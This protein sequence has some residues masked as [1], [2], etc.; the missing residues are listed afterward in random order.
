MTM[1]SQSLEEIRVYVGTY[2]SGGSEGI[3]LYRMD[4]STGALERGRTVARDIANP[5]FVALDPQGRTLYSVEEMGYSDGE[6]SGAVSA[7]SIDPE[8]GDLTY[9]NRQ[10]SGGDGPCHLSVDGTGRYVL[11]AN[12][13][14]GNASML[15]VLEGGGLG[16][17]TGFVQHEGGSVLERQAGP[18]A[19][20]INLDPGNRYAFVADLGLD[21]VMIYRLDLDRGKLI[22]GD[23]PWAEVQAGAGPRHFDFHPNGRY[24]YL[25]NEIGN[26]MT[27]FAYD[28]ARGA[29][30]EVQTASTLPEAFSGTSYTADVH[31]APSGKFVYGSNRGHDS[32][33][34][35]GI[36]EGTGRMTPLG[37]EP[38]QG[39]SPRNF[40]IDPT[41]TFLLAANQETGNVVTFRMDQG[42]GALVPTGHVTEIPAPVCLEMIAIAS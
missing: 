21:K 5:S 3:Y 2:T 40:G 4:P 22:P 9:L 8:T 34:I 12:Y 29:L 7:F 33:A 30:R 16:E 11:V 23:E 31:V 6:P 38:T 41:G 1:T 32:I 24:A 10:P 27:A 28:E 15:P 26:T 18:H 37:C 39:Q 35:F 17:A 36:D 20:S 42:T 25:I 19:H 14:S 13:G